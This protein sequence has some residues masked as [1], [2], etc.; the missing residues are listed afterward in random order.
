MILQ[1]FIP[2]FGATA[3][4][5]VLTPICIKLARLLNLIDRPESASHKIHKTPVPKAGGTALVLAVFIVTIVGGKFFTND[6]RAILL[7]SIPVFVFGIL[8]DA[9]GLSVG[10]KLLGQFIASLLLIWQGTYVRM[11]QFPV[12]DIAI[13]FFWLI[14]MTNAFNLVDSMDGLVLGL[15]ATASAF[16]VLVTLDA[17]QP[18]LT[19][20][21]VVLLGSCM[22]LFYFNSVPA[23]T[24]LGDSG[25]QYSGFV[26]AALA[27]EY[28]PPGLPQP[29]SWFVPI[30]LLSIPIFDTTFA[31]YSRLRR[32]LPIYQAGQDHIYHRLIGLGMSPTQA[33]TAMHVAAFIVGC[34]AFI[35][36]PLHPIWANVIFVSAMLCGGMILLWLEKRTREL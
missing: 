22:G 29:S 26:L 1:F 5:L 27:I 3:I 12:F 28:T 25:A 9:K 20:L 30:L 10:W 16:F 4:T 19:Y 18:N 21:S 14:G 6:I 2:L 34:L 8:D 23:K 11:L 13:T 31:V 15:T 17:T 36:L 32:K 24:F 7:A 35:A 33:V